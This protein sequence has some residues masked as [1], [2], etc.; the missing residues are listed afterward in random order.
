MDA[1]DILVVDDE[2]GVCRTLEKVLATAG[3]EVRSAESLKAAREARRERVPDVVFLDLRLPDGNGLSL[4]E[5]LK[6]EVPHVEVVIVT[7][8]VDVDLARR[9]LLLGAVDLIE[10]P[11]TSAAVGA[12]L[13][14]VVGLPEALRQDQAERKAT[15]GLVGNS[16]SFVQACHDLVLLGAAEQ[17]PGLLVGELGTGRTL[18]SRAIHDASPR[19][20][21]PYVAA[22]CVTLTAAQLLGCEAGTLAVAPEGQAGCLE[23]AEG[24]TLFLSE[25]H[26]LRQELQGL[27]LEVLQNKTFRRVGALNPTKVDVRIVAATHLEPD[28]LAK[29]LREDLY[30]RLAVMPI[31]LPP[32]RERGDDVVL[33]AQHFLRES[34]ASI[35]RGMTGFSAQAMR[36]LKSYPWPGNVRELKNVVERAVILSQ[37]GSR[38]ELSGLRLGSSEGEEMVEGE[39]RLNLPD[40]KIASAE[41]A[42]IRLALEET[43]GHKTLAAELLGINRATLYNKLK[44][45][46]LAAPR[47]T[48]SG[49]GPVPPSG[50]G[51]VEDDEKQQPPG[52]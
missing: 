8:H 9:A 38:V 25:I 37:H 35:G 31:H 15:G 21:G 45:Y 6:Q 10:K 20:A 43:K 14:G 29:H 11:F 16:A 48:P 4:L 40:Y 2:P 19:S 52:V 49:S 28:L 47:R 34:A 3:H 27:L 18:G 44:A 12:V 32:L 46:G 30:Y 42:L 23:S 24:G 41:R 26:E 1:L 50:S 33:L 36:R 51:P 22:S 5:E 17:T 7:A 13:E 39:V